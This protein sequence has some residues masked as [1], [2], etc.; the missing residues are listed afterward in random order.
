MHSPYQVLVLDDEEV[1]CERL[2]AHLEKKGLEVETFTESQ[3]A[4]DRMAEKTFDVVI[5]DVKMEGPSGLDVLHFVR[6][7][8]PGTQVI[9]ITGYG[10]MEDFREAEYGGAFEFITKPFS[11]KTIEALTLKAAKKARKHGAGDE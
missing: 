11:S 7:E 2:K 5:T 3:M 6:R 4:I 1:V 10:S 9:V 8:N